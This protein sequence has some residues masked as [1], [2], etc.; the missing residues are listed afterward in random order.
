MNVGK[1]PTGRFQF[2]NVTIVILAT[3]A[4]STEQRRRTVPRR[5]VFQTLIDKT[6]VKAVIVEGMEDAQ[7]PASGA[8]RHA[9][10]ATA[11]CALAANSRNTVKNAV[12]VCDKIT[13]GVK[14]LAGLRIFAEV[15]KDVFQVS[16]AIRHQL[17]DG[18]I[19]IFAAI[20]GRAKNV[21]G[22]I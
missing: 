19:V 12:L 4:H 18:A 17:E 8:V 10:D 22:L 15:V 3:F 14:I 11:V 21:A 5:A 13:L 20:T 7:T 2:I 6:R 9:E 16:R 1:D